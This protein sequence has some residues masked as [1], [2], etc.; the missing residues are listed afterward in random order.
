[1]SDRASDPVSDRVSVPTDAGDMPAY[2]WLPES[3]TG[4][5]LLLL[6]EIFGVSDYIQ[7]RGADLAAAGY[8][9]LAPELYW[10]LDAAAMDES[11]PGA[12]EEAMSRAQRLDWDTTGCDARAAL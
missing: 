9:V 11:S 12:I 1:M 8:V 4:P 3:S 5:G 10:R 2:R 6:Q 7:Q